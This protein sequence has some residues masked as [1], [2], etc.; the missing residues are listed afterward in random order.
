MSCYQIPTATVSAD[1]AAA[2]GE[3]ETLQQ[4][5]QGGRRS[6]RSL[7]RNLASQASHRTATLNYYCCWQPLSTSVVKLVAAAVVESCQNP[8]SWSL[9]S[10][11]AAIY[12][13]ASLS[14]AKLLTLVLGMMRAAG[15]TCCLSP[16][17]SLSP[18]GNGYYE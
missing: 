7:P 11:E 1:T 13:L 15:G 5:C 9:M 10:Q 4:L 3:R 12:L 17:F 8:S 18:S 2:F 14:H 6:Y 16:S